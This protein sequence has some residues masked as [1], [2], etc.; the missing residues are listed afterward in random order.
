MHFIKVP[1]DYAVGFQRFKPGRQ[2]IGRYAIERFEKRL[3]S[4]PAVLKK[5]AQDEE[6]PAITYHIR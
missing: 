3:K 4:T 2:R 5:I 6:R 1:L